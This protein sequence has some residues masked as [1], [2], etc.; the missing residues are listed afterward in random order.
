MHGQHG[1]EPLQ[2]EASARTFFA[3]FAA[4]ERP[5]SRDHRVLDADRGSNRE[6]ISLIEGFLRNFRNEGF[7]ECEREEG[8]RST[9]ADPERKPC[10]ANMNLAMC[11]GDR[12]C[13]VTLSPAP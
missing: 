2:I 8:R 3:Q 6:I 7:I 5:K 10:V 1:S 11:D 12:L 13:T 9:I 4:S